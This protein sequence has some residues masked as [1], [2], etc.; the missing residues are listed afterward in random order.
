MASIKR[1][2]ADMI[3]F[4]NQTD[5]VNVSCYTSLKSMRCIGVTNHGMG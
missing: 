2:E 5:S 4:V 1:L 3:D